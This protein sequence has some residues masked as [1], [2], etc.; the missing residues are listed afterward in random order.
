MDFS[1]EKDIPFKIETHND[2]KKLLFLIE[3]VFNSFNKIDKNK[4]RYDFTFKNGKILCS[5]NKRQDFLKGIFGVTDFNLVSMGVSCFKQN[6][7]TYFSIKY[8][9][10]L[11]IISS[12]KECLIK[13]SEA[14]DNEVARMKDN[15]QAV[16][17]IEKH[18]HKTTNINQSGRIN[19]NGDVTTSNIAND[20]AMVTTK[21]S[22][23]EQKS[24]SF[25]KPIWQ[26]LIANWIWWMLAIFGGA[27][28]TIAALLVR[29]RQG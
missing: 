4:L 20:G 22:A 2:A 29:I 8:F 28:V 12:N 23:E 7:A 5:T 14:Y 24:S 10:G 15:K 3:A 17:I 19:I 16:I 11:S 6:A 27:I 25:A 26:S 9:C 13:A 1:I 21:H 18:E